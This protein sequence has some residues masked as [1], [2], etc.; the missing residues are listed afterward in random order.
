MKNK[1][2]K[3][4]NEIQDSIKKI[5]AK[6]NEA[7]AG[8]KIDLIALNAAPKFLIEDLMEE[9]EIEIRLQSLVFE[10]YDQLN[11]SGEVHLSKD[12]DFPIYDRHV[13]LAD[14]MIISGNTHFYICN[15]LKQ[16]LP[17]SLSLVCVGSKPKFLAKELPHCYSLFNFHNEWVEGYGIGGEEF[18]K[19]KYLVD[20]KKT[21]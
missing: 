3:D 2:L 10:D 8:K 12:L 1:L 6:I 9:L 5:A 4:S 20:L 13:L 11:Q 18:S 19:E 16:R 7:Y 15:Y 17:K 21:L 14:G